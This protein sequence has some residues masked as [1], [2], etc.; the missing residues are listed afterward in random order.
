MTPQLARRVTIVG[1]LALA[2]FAII[3]FRLWFLQILSGSQYAK[4][5]TV[6]YVRDIDIAAP[7]GEILDSAGNPLVTSELA[8]A[9]EI[10]PDALPVPV[11]FENPD[12]LID[13]PVRDYG[14]YDRLAS[15][16]QISTKPSACTV[17]AHGTHPLAP[18]PCMVA[19][20]VETLPFAPVTVASDVSEDVAY[21]W[22]ERQSEF[23]GVEVTQVSLRQYPDGSLAAQVLG[24]VGPI[25]PT[26]LKDTQHFKGVNRQAV[27]GQ[28]GLEWEYQ[29]YLQGEDGDER[30]RV[31]SF[32]Q[33]Q[34][35]LPPVASKP[36]YN[37]RTSLNTQLQK[38]GEAALAHSIATNSGTGGAFV[39]MDPD[40]G[41][42]YAM[43]SAPTFDPGIFTKPISESAY[44]ALTSPANGYPLLNRAIDSAGPTGSTFK[45][46]TATAALQS[47]AWLLDDTFDDTGQFCIDGECRRNSGGAAYG[48]VDLVSAIRVSD[49]VF[50]YN[51]GAA[52]NV[53]NPN[54]NPQGGAL[55]QWAKA[56]GIGQP[57][58][59]D[60]PDEATGTL[61]TPGWRAH[62]NE[63]EQECEDATGPYAY[64][65]GN[66]VG[67]AKLKGWHRSPKHPAAN[68]G[69][70]I[71]I[72]PPESW[73]VGDNINMAVGQGDVQVTPLQL[74]LVYAAI[75]NGGTI[76]RPHLGLDIQSSDG[77]VLQKLVPP[78]SRHIDIDPAYLD[79]IREGLREAASQHGGTS[80]DVFGNFPEQVYGK[81][82][83]AQYNNQQDYAWYACF[84][85]DWATGKPILIVVTVEQGGFGAVAAAPVAREMLS[86]WFF[87][88]PGAYVAGSST[89]L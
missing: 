47:G 27:V 50:F 51:L 71:A 17:A 45:V 29:Q 56:F 76:V 83:T 8:Y 87:G 58:G 2:M 57:T 44:E 64:T 65:N 74:A 54:A 15:V 77:T 32:G 52:T 62:Q 21:Y 89:T 70:G 19:Q 43:G 81:T 26:E 16:L 4:A 67:P 40:T 61:P 35:Y 23:P 84:V 66:S 78:P 41:E 14:V 59:I 86:Q 48:V 79:A 6:N 82:G 46:I 42:V 1:S 88:K 3:F 12:N 53:T 25:N 22:A 18:I 11:T 37:L 10:E 7:R 28:S 73:T 69:C 49:D 72:I 80:A 5:A 68:G 13:Q 55:Q 85:P 33:F 20:Q 24:T 60:V 36:G 31:N 75:A 34:G 63:L 39:A 38:V 30:V 9:V